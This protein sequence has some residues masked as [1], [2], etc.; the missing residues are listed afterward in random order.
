MGQTE[1]LWES[2]GEVMPGKWMG[3]SQKNMADGAGHGGGEAGGAPRKLSKVVVNQGRR[4]K[5]MEGRLGVAA[6]VG[7][8]TGRGRLAAMLSKALQ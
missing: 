2:E 8:V 4:R 3:S 5:R 1:K 6:P 7:L